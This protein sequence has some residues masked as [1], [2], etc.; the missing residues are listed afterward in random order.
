MRTTSKSC[1]AVCPAE[2]APR[3]ARLR[4]LALLAAG[5]FGGLPALVAQS[6]GNPV[7][8]NPVA[9]NPVAGNPPAGDAAAAMEFSRSVVEAT[10]G[11]SKRAQSALVTELQVVSS[12]LAGSHFVGVAAAVERGEQRLKQ[13]LTSRRGKSGKIKRSKGGSGKSDLNGWELPSS[14]AYEFGCET[15]RR[16]SKKRRDQQEL[17]REVPVRLASLGMLPRSDYAF[18]ELLARLDSDRSADEFAVFLESWRNGDESFYQALDRTAGTSDSV[19]FYDAML[20]DFVETFARGRSDASKAVRKSLDASHDALHAA[21]LTYRQYRAFREAVALS[22]LL[23]PDV[24]LPA[25][26]RRYEEKQSG[27]SLREQVW[28]VLAV[29][30]GD[31][32]AVVDTV[33]KTAAALPAPLWSNTYD[34]SVA[35]THSVFDPAMQKM[36]AVA[37]STDE[38]LATAR[39]ARLVDAQRIRARMAVL[40]GLAPI[41]LHE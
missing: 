26:L 35:W 6:A 29:H 27:Y 40:A 39:A 8:G 37:A 16:A 5:V 12:E 15:V 24:P 33:A 19:F 2:V 3:A 30:D 17:E 36:L 31:P 20:G 38:F 7:A 25:R 4:P 41:A 13:S 14:V 10:Q 22:L 28:M 9:G 34:P 23:P 18:V 1:R 11:K 21:F 32:V